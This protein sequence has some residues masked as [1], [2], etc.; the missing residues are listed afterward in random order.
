MS[1]LLTPTMKRPV[2]IVRTQPNASGEW[3]VNLPQRSEFARQHR[4]MLRGME[5]LL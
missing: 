3:H 2:R 1:H 5:A 4:D